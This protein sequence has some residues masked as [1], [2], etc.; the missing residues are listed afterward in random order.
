MQIESDKDFTQLR[1][2]FSVWRKRFPMFVHD[3]QQIEKIIDKHIQ[4]HSKIMVMHRQTHNRSYLEKAQKEIE[5]IEKQIE[6]QESVLKNVED[7]LSKT[8][9]KDKIQYNSALN[10]YEQEKAQLDSLYKKWE[11]KSEVLLKTEF[12]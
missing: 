8:D 1:N 6:Q 4:Q 10:R 2:Q 12:H 7:D 9:Y 11:E 5:Q 3:V